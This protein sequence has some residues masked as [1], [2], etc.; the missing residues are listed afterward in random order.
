MITDMFEQ[1]E[2]TNPPMF[3]DKRMSEPKRMERPKV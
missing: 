3:K 2:A 1:K